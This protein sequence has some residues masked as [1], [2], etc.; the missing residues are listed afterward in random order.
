MRSVH[1]QNPAL[2]LPGE[3]HS[4]NGLAG[5]QIR[6][7][8]ADEQ[9]V[10]REGL[11]ALLTQQSDMTV[12]ACVPNG[13]S[14]ADAFEELLPDVVLFDMAEFNQQNCRAVFEILKRHRSA[15]I[16]VFTASYGEE[17]VYQAMQSG[18]RGYLLKTSPVE[19]IVACIHSVAREQSWIPRAI[20]EI[21]ARRMAAPK[22][23]RR[24]T[25]VL[26]A[27]AEGRSN[28]E[29]ASALNLSEG[30]VKVHVTHILEKLQV[31][32]RT[33]ALAAAASRGLIS[34]PALQ[35][36]GKFQ[37]PGLTA[38]S[39]GDERSMNTD[40]QIKEAAMGVS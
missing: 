24:E 19:E 5:K 40:G 32:G 1:T 33:G 7:L 15:R 4:S 34:W 13:I 30:T 11:A 31:G 16:V 22:L 36:N 26:S 35:A 18:A 20:E 17:L 10:V 6:I 38:T 37:A 28:R 23:T 14:A 2:P 21:L 9:P 25:D 3:E 12:A 27:M 29:I 39:L 8:I